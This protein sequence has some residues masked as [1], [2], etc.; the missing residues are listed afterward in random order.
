MAEFCLTLVCAA[1]LEERVLDALLL[2]PEL[3][4][5]TSVPAAVHGLAQHRLD[6]AEQV[7]GRAHAVQVQALVPQERSDALLA[8][9]RREFAGARVRYW[10]TPVIES[11]VLS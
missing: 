9:I 3:T 4:I 1:E 8:G 6:E 11:G 10:L 5:F 2:T 7:L